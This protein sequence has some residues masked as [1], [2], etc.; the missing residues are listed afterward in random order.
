M[1]HYPDDLDQLI[2]AEPAAPMRK[3]LMKAVRRSHLSATILDAAA[4]RLPVDDRSVD[5]VV[6]T[7]VLCTVD[8]PAVVLGVTSPGRSRA[9]GL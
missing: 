6:S 7:L 2:L 8:R 5:T 9:R 4:E 1:P 3:R